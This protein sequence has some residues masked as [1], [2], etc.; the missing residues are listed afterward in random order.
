MTSQFR[1]PY[2]EA[3]QRKVSLSSAVETGTE[4]PVVQSAAGSVDVNEMIRRFT[5]SGEMPR[6][7]VEAVYGDYSDAVTYHEAVQRLRSAAESF[8]RLPSASRRVFE[9][10]PERLLVAVE[11]A[12]GGDVEAREALA[13]A[14]LLR[15]PVAIAGPSEPAV[16]VAPA[17]S[18]PAPGAGERLAL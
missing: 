1:M 7:A 18:A 8:D 14:G 16:V 9:N 4:T 13:A 12:A 5:R 11:A 3:A 6:G 17:V 10:S 15:D 2:D